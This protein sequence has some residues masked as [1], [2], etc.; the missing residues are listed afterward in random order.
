MYYCSD[1]IIDVFFARNSFL[2]ILDQ[3]LCAHNV[4]RKRSMILN[5][6]SN[7]HLRSRLFVERTRSYKNHVITA[8][9]GF[10]NIDKIVIPV[11]ADSHY[12][13]YVVYMETQDVV[14]ID[15]LNMATPKA[16]SY[17]DILAFL[18]DES[19]EANRPFCEKEWKFVRAKVVHQGNSLD[20]GFCVIKYALLVLQDL[21]FDLQVM[22]YLVKQMMYTLMYFI[23]IAFKCFWYFIDQHE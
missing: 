16:L 7:N 22:Y 9:L 12:T 2:D 17:N 6:A 15:T 5:I 3:Y 10:F 1:N 18:K 4:N 8:S 19:I 14:F 23:I 13:M 21:P 20:C 11:F